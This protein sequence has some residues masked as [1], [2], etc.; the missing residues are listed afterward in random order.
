MKTISV[1]VSEQD[2]EEFRRAS[3]RKGRPIAELIREAM[4]F[5]RAEKLAHREP[6]RDLPVLA[7]H[8]P[9]RRLPARTEVYD[10][11]FARTRK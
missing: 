4:G 8:R 9:R 6:L 7:G 3:R 5:Y 11:I 1:S 10:E 2:Y